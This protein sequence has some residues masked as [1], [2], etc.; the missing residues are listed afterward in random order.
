MSAIKKAK[1]SILSRND[2]LNR[3]IRVKER[4]KRVYNQVVSFKKVLIHYSG[5][6]LLPYSIKT[7]F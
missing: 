6:K 4:K 3:S 1:Q 7:L 2:G 5:N